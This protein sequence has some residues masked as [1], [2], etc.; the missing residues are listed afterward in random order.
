MPANN[1]ANK[2]REGR[3]LALGGDPV[4]YE[5]LRELNQHCETVLRTLE[6]CRRVIPKSERKYCRL[7]IQEARALA[8]QSIVEFLN[9]REIAIASDVSRQ[10]TLLEK[11]LFT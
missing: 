10:R 5:Q 1:P 8:S 2:N 3:R 9:E 7:L 4:L 6:A 11:R